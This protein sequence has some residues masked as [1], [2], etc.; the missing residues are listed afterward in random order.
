MDGNPERIVP[1][2][3]VFTYLRLLKSTVFRLV[4]SGKSSA[5]NAGRQYRFLE[6]VSD[7]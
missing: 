4:Q 1:L 6:G 5:Q 3:D 7:A 2:D